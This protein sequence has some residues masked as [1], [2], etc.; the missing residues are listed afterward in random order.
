MGNGRDA[1]RM[2]R[3]R[4]NMPDVTFARPSARC[5]GRNPELHLRLR[6]RFTP[7]SPP[8]LIVPSRKHPRRSPRTSRLPT[9]YAT[10]QLQQPAAG[11]LTAAAP[12]CSTARFH[13]PPATVAP[14]AAAPLATSQWLWLW[15]AA[16]AAAAA[17]WAGLH[18]RR[19]RAG[20]PSRIRQL[21]ERPD[22]ADGLSDR[23]ECCKRRAGVHGAERMTSLVHTCPFALRRRGT[24]AD[25]KTNS[26][27]V[28]PLCQRLR[29]KTLLQRLQLVR[30]DQAPHRALPLVASAL[31]APA[32]PLQQRPRWVLHATTG[33]C[34]LARHVHP[35][36][37]FLQPPTTRPS[38]NILQQ[39][40]S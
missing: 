24:A 33:R 36:Y 27:P 12:P 22:G 3:V 17:G 8:R 15:T 19:G 14:A 18:G 28:R 30:C 16:P 32:A 31:V 11:A 26:S 7:N 38:T 40:P 9:R 25:S 4:R 20:R 2:T 1:E 39:W 6:L 5:I 21:H 34:E 13:S 29:P 37:A 10:P 23:K 35:K